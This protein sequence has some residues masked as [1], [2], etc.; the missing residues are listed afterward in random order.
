MFK[1]MFAPTPSWIEKV[2]KTGKPAQAT[3]FSSPNDMFKGISCYQ[4]RE[5]YRV[6]VQRLIKRHSRERCA[7][8]RELP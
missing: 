8:V 5:T 4:G 1:M 6:E 7:A 3:L 2:E